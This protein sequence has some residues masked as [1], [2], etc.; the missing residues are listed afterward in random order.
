MDWY[1]FKD[2]VPMMESD[3]NLV[4]TA[5]DDYQ[6]NFNFKGLKCPK[7]GAS[8]IPENLAIGRLATAEG[9]VEGK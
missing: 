4:Y 1:C 2:K 8:Y 5:R 9:M 7:C 3:I 6:R